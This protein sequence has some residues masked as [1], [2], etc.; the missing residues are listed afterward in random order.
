MAQQMYRYQINLF[1]VNKLFDVL[2]PYEYPADG[3]D[4]LTAQYGGRENV[5]VTYR[6]QA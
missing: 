2:V 4:I 6:G 1:R 3:V 5:R